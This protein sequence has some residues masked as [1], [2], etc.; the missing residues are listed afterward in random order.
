MKAFVHTESHPILPK[1]YLSV[2][3]NPYRA[4]NF[5]FQAPASAAAAPFEPL[6]RAESSL[7]PL[8]IAAAVASSTPKC[9]GLSDS[10][11][12]VLRTVGS[13]PARTCGSARSTP[14]ACSAARLRSASAAAATRSRSARS[15]YDAIGCWGGGAPGLGRRRAS[16]GGGALGGVGFGDVTVIAG[17]P[18]ASPVP[19]TSPGSVSAASECDAVSSCALSAAS[20]L[21]P[22]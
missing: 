8:P 17:L 15:A 11:P 20:I 9:T 18:S 1:C 6:R 5:E 22:L 4:K 16:R 2:L 13:L 19:D 3:S 10:P 14:L 21:E 12:R 7:A